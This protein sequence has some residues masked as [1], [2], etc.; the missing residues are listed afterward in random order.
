MKDIL[1]NEANVGDLFAYALIVGRSANMAIYELREITDAGK[2][3]A[4]KVMESY[5]F[6]GD[7]AP[8]HN[9]KRPR[10]SWF[11]KQ[12]THKW[13]YNEKTGR[14]DYIQHTP[15]EQAEYDAKRAKKTVTLSM[16][17]ERAIILPNDYLDHLK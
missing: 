2:A 7:L 17:H 4:H 8:H 14:G 13:V 9:D 11:T 12:H 15:E 6:G 16:F 1:G 5:G 3:K 10:P